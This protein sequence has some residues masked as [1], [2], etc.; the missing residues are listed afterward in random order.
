MTW[1]IG[2]TFGGIG[3]LRTLARRTAKIGNE[4][5]IVRFDLVFSS[6]LFLGWFSDWISREGTEMLWLFRAATVS[7]FC[8]TITDIVTGT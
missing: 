1:W 8:D 5:C 3:E 7:G 6:I 4:S 2:Y